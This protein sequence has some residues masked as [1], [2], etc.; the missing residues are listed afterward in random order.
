MNHNK[1]A[2]T[3]KPARVTHDQCLICTVISVCGCRDRRGKASLAVG[4]AGLRHGPHGGVSALLV[5]VF[6][7]AG[8]LTILV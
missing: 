5:V 6:F 4:G 2:C 1:Q 3:L 8:F 7:F